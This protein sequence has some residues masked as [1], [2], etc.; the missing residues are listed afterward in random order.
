MT[1]SVRCFEVLP[2]EE[3]KGFPQG[4]AMFC[5]AAELLTESDVEQKFL[6]PC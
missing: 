1:I 5:S 6:L 2:F 3:T 4:D